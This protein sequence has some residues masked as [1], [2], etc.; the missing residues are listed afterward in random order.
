VRWRSGAR[1]GEAGQD[2]EAVVEDPDCASVERGGDVEG[3]AAGRAVRRQWCLVVNTSAL[4]SASTR[5]GAA[6]AVVSTLTIVVIDVAFPSV[7][8]AR[9]DEAVAAGAEGPLWAGLPTIVVGA[10]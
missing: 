4:E 7:V 2:G 5:P 10:P 3:A 8:G 1:A 6:G 9:E